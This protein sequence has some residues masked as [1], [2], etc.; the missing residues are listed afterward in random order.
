MSSL[1]GGGG[2]QTQTSSSNST[3]NVN[4]APWYEQYTK[5]LLSRATT[6]SQQPFQP[7]DVSKMYAPFT[8]DQA[9]AFQQI[10]NNQ[11]AFAPYMQ[12]GTGAL[13]SVAGISPM[14]M[15]MPLINAAAQG[16]TGMQ[17]GQGFLTSG[18]QTWNP[19]TQSQY[20]NPFLAGSVNYANQLATNN[21]LEQ[22]LPGINAQ[23][24]KSGGGL[25]GSRYQ[26]FM[27]RAVRDF[28]NSMFGQAQTA[29]ANNYWQGANQFN[30]DMSRQ[31]QAGTNLGGLANST[32]GAL[33]NLG[34]TAAGIGNMGIGA[35]IN[36]A[37]AYSGLGG[38]LSNINLANTNAL[39]QAGNQQQQQAQ[40][41][42]T[43]QYQQFQQGVQFPYQQL[44]F[45]NQIQQGLRIPQTQTSQS[46]STQNMSANSSP[47][48]M[49]GILGTLGGVLGLPGVSNWAGGMLGGL[50]GG[51]GPTAAATPNMGGVSGASW[52]PN[53]GYSFPS[54]SAGFGAGPIG[55]SGSNWAYST[56][57]KRGGHIRRAAKRFSQGG[58]VPIV[59]ALNRRA[60]PALRAIAGRQRPPVPMPTPP[61]G[62]LSREMASFGRGALSATR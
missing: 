56:A 61:S 31:I 10:R 20:T 22:T 34:Q 14:A 8:P 38:Q 58:T 52:T 13:N 25:G 16:P 29:A 43:A 18:A 4:Y 32:M 48:I 45:L 35:G 44:N 59:A 6:L 49:S 54:G 37:N 15:G 42:L 9:Q 3:Q 26:D 39:L 27:N 51:G 46:Y 33:G 17:A 36:L 30:N 62:A 12:A 60:E 21:F 2:G 23:F 57:Q 11:G 41:P 19:A 24:V 1:F 40:L 47:S 7:Y 55:G 28:S 5:D 50:F 53:G